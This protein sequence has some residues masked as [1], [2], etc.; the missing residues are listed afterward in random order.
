MTTTQLIAFLIGLSA[1]YG[2]GLVK[3]IA[4]LIHGNPA[5]PGES[6]ADYIKRI[7]AQ[8]DADAANISA[9]NN[10]IQGE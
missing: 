7:G 8:I 9:Q 6:D 3:D 4:G 1:Q 2:P 10:A 5:Q